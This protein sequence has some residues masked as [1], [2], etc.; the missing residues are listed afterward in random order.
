VGYDKDYTPGSHTF[1]LERSNEYENPAV[2]EQDD[3]QRQHVMQHLTSEI[4][5]A[6]PPP[7]PGTYANGMRMYQTAPYIEQPSPQDGLQYPSIPPPPVV[8]QELNYQ[9]QPMYSAP[10][11]PAMNSPESDGVWRND[12]TSNLSDFFGELKIDHTAVGKI[13]KYTSK[14]F[15]IITFL[16]TLHC[17]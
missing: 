4:V 16:S 9:P 10:A 7:V 14:T 6:L 17:E 3:Y 5:P 8:G 12:N 2:D 11:A 13:S 15:Q 1:E